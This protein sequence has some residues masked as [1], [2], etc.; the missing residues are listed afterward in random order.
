MRRI[1]AV[2]CTAAPFAA[3]AVAAAS[4]RRDLRMLWMAVAATVVARLVLAALVTRWGA[5]IAAGVAL[6]AAGAAA[7]ALAVLLGA[8]AVFGVVAVAVV[9]AGCATAG[10]ALARRGRSAAP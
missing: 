9:L 3:A 6:A 8:R 7:A 10:A 2:L 5:G 1:L 4:V